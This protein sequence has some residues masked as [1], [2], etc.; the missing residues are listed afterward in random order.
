MKLVLNVIRTI[1][2]IGARS[3]FERVLSFS[4]TNTVF[5]PNFNRNSNS[6]RKRLA[7]VNEN[8]GCRYQSAE[9]HVVQI[10]I[11]KERETVV[12]KG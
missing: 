12:R 8:N 5:I 7:E 3:V 2:Q 6:Y 9:K 1:F 11:R 4:I 10:R